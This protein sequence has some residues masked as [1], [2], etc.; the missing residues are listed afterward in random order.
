MS[1]ILISCAVVLGIGVGGRS[2]TEKSSIKA[3]GI[4]LPSRDSAEDRSQLLPV[5][6]VKLAS[7]TTAYEMDEFRRQTRELNRMMQAESRSCQSLSLFNKAWQPASGVTCEEL[8]PRKGSAGF[9]QIVFAMS[10]SP[11]GERQ[12]QIV[13]LGSSKMASSIVEYVDVKASRGQCN[14][15]VGTTQ[16]FVFWE[17]PL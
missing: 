16:F 14:D 13:F 3:R 5:G 10:T 4:V 12:E 9:G 1:A 6:S 7:S 8:S 2:E 11:H 15:D 17:K